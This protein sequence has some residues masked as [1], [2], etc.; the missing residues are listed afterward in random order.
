MFVGQIS[1]TCIDVSYSNICKQIDDGL[2]AMVS[3]S[4]VVRSVIRVIK[5][6]AF[7]DMLC[8][9]DGLNSNASLNRT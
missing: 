7:K 2:K 6:G 1:D 9:H 4:E 5:P 3:E 8:N